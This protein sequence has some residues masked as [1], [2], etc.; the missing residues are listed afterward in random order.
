MRFG[1]VRSRANDQERTLETLWYKR[2]WEPWAGRAAAPGLGGE[3]DYTP[4]RGRV[5]ERILPKELWKPGFQD[6]E[7]QLLLGKGHL[8]PSNET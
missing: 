7:G 5:G 6:L 3:A 8:P 4:G 2:G 1:G